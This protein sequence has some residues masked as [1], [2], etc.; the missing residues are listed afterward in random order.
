MAV[1]QSAD[2]PTKNYAVMTPVYPDTGTFSKG[3]LTAVTAG[4]DGDQPIGSI[5]FDSQDSDGYYFIMRPTT[6]SS[7]IGAF[8]V[9][10][11]T[12]D[13]ANEKPRNDGPS[14]QPHL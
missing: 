2:S 4:N 3:N 1:T 12:V 11:A 8:A 7:S 10:V 5:A 14:L 9:G 6:T 13:H